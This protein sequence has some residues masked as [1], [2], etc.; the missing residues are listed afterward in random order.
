[1]SSCASYVS[2][3]HDVI[4]DV[5]RWQSRSNFE[6][7]ISPSMFEL[8]RRSKAQNVGNANGYLYGMFNFRY[9]LRWKG[10]S[11]AQN[12]G[13]FE[14]FEILN[15]ASIWP[16][17]W[18]DRPK[19]CPKSY[20][21]D[22]DVS[23]TSQGGL[24]FGPLY[25]FI[26]EITIFFIIANKT[27]KDIIIKLP[28]H[29]YHEIMTTFVWIHIHDVIDD[30]TRSQSRSNFEIDISPSILRLEHRSKIQ[31]V[32]NANGYLFGIFN[33]RYNFRWKRL[34]RDQNGG[35]FKNS[36]ILNTASIWPQIWKGRP[37]L[38]KKK[39]W[40]WRHRWRHRVAPKIPSIFMFRRG[41]LQ[42]HVARAMSRQ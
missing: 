19:L 38:C 6:I 41:W 39:S 7:D 30:V 37:K 5:T 15:T 10:L 11:R 42:E 14:N 27:S 29:Q 28:L 24:E 23:M 12:G 18:K 4:D 25:F 22:D 13:H 9:N 40:W 20:F 34:S 26:N 32:R 8:E 21:H 36:D 17:I 3:T 1:M 2:R 33:F 31:N 16:Q 35:H